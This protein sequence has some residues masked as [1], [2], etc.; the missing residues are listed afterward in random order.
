M[1]VGRFVAVVFGTAMIAIAGWY[2][3]DSLMHVGTALAS[4]NWTKTDADITNVRE[5]VRTGYRHKKTTQF[6]VDYSYTVNGM[7][8]SANWT[9]LSSSINR[10]GKSGFTKGKPAVAY[11]NPSDPSQSRLFNYVGFENIVPILGELFFIGLG[12]SILYD[13][14]FSSDSEEVA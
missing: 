9:S 12:I 13:S 2:F 14:L 4:R 3:V 5:I 7:K 10:R 6:S 1:F 8:Y 11:Y